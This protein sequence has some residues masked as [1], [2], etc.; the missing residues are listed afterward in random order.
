MEHFNKKTIE[1]ERFRDSNHFLTHI[2]KKNLKKFL[3][4]YIMKNKIESL[5]ISNQHLEDLIEQLKNKLNFNNV[6][7]KKLENELEKEKS[8]I[9]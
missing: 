4:I 1:I 8:N 2:F 7:I 9:I 6:L 3:F 5:K